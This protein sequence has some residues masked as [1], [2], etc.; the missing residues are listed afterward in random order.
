VT[1]SD[2]VVSVVLIVY[3][4]RGRVLR[5]LRSALGQGVAGLEVVVVDDASTDGS[6]DVV[7][8][9]GETTVRVIRLPRNSG[10]C[11]VPRN[12]GLDAARGRY[13]LFL[14]SDD[15]LEPGA[16]PALVAEA[17]STGV[18]IVMG[19]CIRV[20]E[21]RSSTSSWM[22]HLYG[23]QGVTTT[24][25][26]PALVG[27][28]LVVDKLFRRDLFERNGLRFPTDLHYEDVVLSARLWAAADRV[29]VREI[30]VYRWHVRDTADDRSIT[31]SLR[32]LANAADRVE[33]NRR[34]DVA[35][36]A[37]DRQDLRAARDAKV[38]AHDLRLLL[39]DVPDLGPDVREAFVAQAAQMAGRL[40]PSVRGSTGQ[41]GA[42][43]IAALDQGDVQEVSDVADLVFR[44]RLVR[45]L[46]RRD[47]AWRWPGLQGPAGDVSDLVTP[48]MTRGRVLT[49]D[50]TAVSA[51]GATLRIE[52]ITRVMAGR[53][54]F[55]S[56]LVLAVDRRRRL[57]VALARIASRGRPR[58]GQAAWSCRV[59]LELPLRMVAP[60]SAL[61]LW[62]W[63]G[64]RPAP[65]Q[66]PRD[67]HAKPIS[68]RVLGAPVQAEIQLGPLGRL[69]VRRAP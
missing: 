8:Q 52:G 41:P 64:G 60:G 66:L 61:D 37:A 31:N 6:A 48:L 55:P 17:E 30:P 27:D 53:P 63:S 46:E 7:E 15:E 62:I 50:L 67:W 26:Q 45:P 4:D 18:D 25:E 35:L 33:A 54:G 57:P 58:G 38:L 59:G 20:Y 32:E 3:N 49:H 68:E 11:G 21:S 40:D 5:A 2:V 69:S 16:V 12:A 29:S 39:W 51:S 10:G 13:V 14:D 24:R 36:A 43:L 56:S 42:L 23:R 19:R 28:T 9:L 1:D 34:A 44:R 47:D 65:L 22:P